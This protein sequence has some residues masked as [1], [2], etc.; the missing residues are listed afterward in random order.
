MF[1]A[2]ADARRASGLVVV[3]FK[4]LRPLVLYGLNAS[5]GGRPSTDFLSS[6][7]IGPWILVVL[8]HIHL[9]LVGCY[10]LNSMFIITN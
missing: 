9:H 2:I 4:K 7:W 5:V 1:L 8:T 10:P 3:Q 6:S